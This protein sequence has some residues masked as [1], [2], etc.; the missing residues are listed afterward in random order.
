[1][2]TYKGKDYELTQGYKGIEV[3]EIPEYD[4]VIMRKGV[5]NGGEALWAC[6]GG[7]TDTNLENGYNAIQKVLL[8]KV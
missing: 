2:F 7:I 4:T 8:Q 3:Y 5:D 1:M 6:T